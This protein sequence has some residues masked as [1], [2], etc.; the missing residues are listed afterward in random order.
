MI[1][2]KWSEEAKKKSL[3][4]KGPILAAKSA[5]KIKFRRIFSGFGS[6]NLGRQKLN[7]LAKF[8]ADFSFLADTAAG[9]L[10]ELFFEKN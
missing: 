10:P 1:S 6:G 7:F 9:N 2:K 5:E 3:L 8:P 4:N